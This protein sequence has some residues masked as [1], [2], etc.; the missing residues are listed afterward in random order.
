ME[1]IG[2][3]VTRR[4]WVDLERQKLPLNLPAF[5]PGPPGQFLVSPIKLRRWF[6]HRSEGVR[7]S[8]QLEAMHPLGRLDN[9]GRDGEA[10]VV[11]ELLMATVV[12]RDKASPVDRRGQ[13]CLPGP[14][15]APR[16][17]DPPARGCE[18]T[19]RI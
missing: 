10:D 8:R 4:L 12:G 7:P 3:I 11:G 19:S 6:T 16:P 9:L 1:W 18:W 2:W 13:L 15:L 17:H 5:G 14:D